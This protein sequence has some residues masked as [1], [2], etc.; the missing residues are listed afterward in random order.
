MLAA[1][2]P[3]ILHYELVVTGWRLHVSQGW[4]LRTLT[5]H[6]HFQSC[7]IIWSMTHVATHYSYPPHTIRMCLLSLGVFTLLKHVLFCC[8]DMS[9]CCSNSSTRPPTFID[10]AFSTSF[11]EPSEDLRLVSILFN[12]SLR[13]RRRYRRLSCRQASPLNGARFPVHSTL[14]V[15]Y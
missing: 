3:G 4:A 8:Q 15:K 6:S 9:R 12:T 10:T 2:Q 11:A 7:D 14:S 13:T 5:L 1:F